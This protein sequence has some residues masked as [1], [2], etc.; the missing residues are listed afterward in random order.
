MNFKNKIFV[1]TGGNGFIGQ[2]TIH[3]I[4]KSGGKVICIGRNKNSAELLIKKNSKD[5]KKNYFFIKADITVEKDLNKIKKIIYTKFNYINGI[6][7]NA[8][9]GKTGAIE[10]SKKKNFE[11]ALNMN[12]FAPFKILFDLKKLLLNGEKKFK[13]AS[14]VVNITSMY[15]LVSPDT[16]IYKS[17]KDFNPIEYGASKAALIQMTKY[18]ACNFSPK[19]I[20]VNCVSLGPFPNKKVSKSLKKQLIKKV[21]LGRFGNA[22]EASKPIKFLLSSDA[23]FIN[24]SNIVVDGGWTSW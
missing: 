13:E 5:F 10:F 15:G 2:S 1:I 21:P 19:K 9:S 18:L 4:L 8:Y 3:N 22:D 23:S 12:L 16:R 7:N 17:K 20:R 6:V 14:S 11:N 24:G